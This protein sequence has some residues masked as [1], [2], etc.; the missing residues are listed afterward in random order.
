MTPASLHAAF[1][2][3]DDFLAVQSPLSV[4]DLGPIT[5]FQE[6]AG[7]EPEHLV[8]LRDRVA[9]LGYDDR[10]AA[11]LLGLLVGLFAAQ[12]ESELGTPE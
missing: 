10:A 7:I 3:V 9:E 5:A 2:R 4:E 11:I 6:A 12:F 8:A 1:D